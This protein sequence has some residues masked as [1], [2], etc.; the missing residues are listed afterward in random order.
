MTMS[1]PLIHKNSQPQQ[2][3]PDMNKLFKQFQ[4]DP[5]KYLSGL[6]IPQELTTPEQMVRHLAANGQI[7][8]AL[9]ATVNAMIGR[10]T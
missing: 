7:P 10:K 9:R 6:N 2:Q 3:Q 8:P 5:R 1:N 4:N